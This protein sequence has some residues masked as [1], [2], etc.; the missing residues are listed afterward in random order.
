MHLKNNKKGFSL[1]EVL[2]SLT[3][4]AM[5]MAAVISNFRGGE[6]RN[7]LNLAAANVAS[8]LRKAQSM[9]SAGTPTRVC[10]VAGVVG[11]NCEDNP[12]L[13]PADCVEHVPFGGYG[14][15]FIPGAENITFFANTDI[16]NDYEELN[17]KVRDLSVSPTGRV[18]ISSIVT[19]TGPSTELQVI[20]MPPANQIIFA[21]D[22]ALDPSEAIITLE[23]INSGETRTITINKISS[24]IDVD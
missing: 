1:I 19:D 6:F 9:V 20:F 7:Q 11:E 8:E 2:V 10:E 16:E 18:M 12:G 4:F 14:L 17:E 15:V 22:V 13:C 5:I 24:R 23:H 21:G 3:I